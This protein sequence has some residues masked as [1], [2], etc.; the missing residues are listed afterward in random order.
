MSSAIPLA[1]D[2]GCRHDRGTDPGGVVTDDNQP[3][4]RSASIEVVIEA[5]PEAVFDEILVLAHQLWQV[6]ESDLV[7]AGRPLLLVHSVRHDD[8]VSCWL[9]WEIAPAEAGASLVRLVHD[10]ADLRPAPPPELSEVIA[11][12]NEQLVRVRSI[13]PQRPMD[14]IPHDT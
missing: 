11:A 9:T 10:E 7:T 12:L 2:S 1:A 3:Q 4:L 14:D 8:M 13:P 6:D 5:T